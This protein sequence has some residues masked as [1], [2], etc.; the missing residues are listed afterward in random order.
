MKRTLQ[1]AGILFLI[2]IGAIVIYFISA[3]NTME[4]EHTVYTSMD[5]PELP[6]VYTQLDGKEINCMHGYVQDMGNQAARESISVLPENREMKIRIAEYGNSITG[7]SYEIRN[8]SMDRLIERTVLTNWESAGGS[9]TASLPIQ[10]LLVRDEPYLLKLTVNTSEKAV[11]YYTRIMWPDNTYA[12]DMVAL[13]DEFTRKSLDYNEA[14]DLVSYLETNS[15]GDNSNLGH[16]TL[17]ASFNHLTWDGLPVKMVGEPQ[18]TLQE[19]DGIMGQICVKYR[20]S[21]EESGSKPVLIDAEDNFTM[22]WNA[23]RIYLMNYE[24]NANEVFDGR[25]AAFSGKRILLGITNDNR[26]KAAKSP[27]SQ[28]LAFKTGRDLWC[29]DQKENHLVRVFTFDSKKDDGVRSNYGDHDIKILSVQDDGTV[30]FLV[31][32]YMNRGKY[33]GRMG[34]VFYNYDWSKD[35]VNEKFFL[36]SDESFEMLQKDMANLS[37]LSENN[38]LYLMEEGTVYGIDL[39]SN[40]SLVVAQG[41][42]VGSFAVSSDGSRIAWQDGSNPYQSEKVHVMD[43]KTAQKQE[44]VGSEND[45]VSVLGFVGDDLIYGLSRPQDSWI[46]NGRLKGIPMYAMYIVDN[47]MHV[48]SEYK[49]D[50]IY[51]SDVVSE[52]GRIHLKRLVRLGDNQ[53]VYQDEDTIVCNQDVD[54]DVMAGIGYFASPTMGR[55]YYVK[56]DS[57]TDGSK[58]KLSAP[59]A[60]SYEYTSTLDMNH[61]GNVQTNTGMVFYAYGGGHYIG[62]SRSFSTAVS[63]A[64]DQMGFV[65][66]GDQHIVWD[67]V[68]KGNSRIIKSP[69]EEAGKATKYLDSFTGSGMYGDGLILIDAGGCSLN[70]VLY[71]VDRGMPVI[72]YVENGKYVLISGYDQYNVTLYN[73]ETQQSWKMGLNDATEYF[74]N[75]Q[76]DFLCALTVN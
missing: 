6:V 70:Q 23:Q 57:D 64:Y 41:L 22:K 75:L 32:G 26:V 49:K 16:V 15:T 35:T 36:P 10:N 50:G 17:K 40:E 11:T 62:P 73:P 54:Q 28:Y 72:A 2:F 52:E 44:I 47:Q 20:V 55:V 9:T 45:Y 59:K 68:N 33:E 29:Y 71:F 61:T 3:R 31:Y 63:M 76:N 30:N 7:I 56:T 60:F 25:T 12:S 37:Y 19:F 65:T 27:G 5:E 43:L 67:R 39:K 38:M 4:K 48:E 34:V 74:K 42:T 69:M 14:K 46:V 66:D 13:A 53:Y 21:L 58:V 51:I 18:I 8:L 1:K 24:R